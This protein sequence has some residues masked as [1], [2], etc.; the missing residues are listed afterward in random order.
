MHKQGKVQEQEND[1]M[2]DGLPDWATRLVKLLVAE[3]PRVI[4]SL[5]L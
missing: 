5:A 2:G 3:D 4:A 1:S